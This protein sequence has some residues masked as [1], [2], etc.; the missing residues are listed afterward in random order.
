MQRG[1]INLD[2]RT[3]IRDSHLRNRIH[4][5]LFFDTSA[6]AWNYYYYFI[7]SPATDLQPRHKSFYLFANELIPW[8]ITLKTVS[9]IINLHSSWE[10]KTETQFLSVSD[11][12]S[13]FS[14]LFDESKGKKQY[15]DD[16]NLKN[17]VI[18]FLMLQTLVCLLNL[19]TR[20]FAKS[21]CSSYT[22]NAGK[23]KHAKLSQP[24]SRRSNKHSN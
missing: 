16:F 11:W 17:F 12:S 3:D 8:K 2:A 14:L 15:L 1:V 18:F 23:S 20:L 24:N 10:F 21:C 19:V 6:S 4:H 5:R 13:T 22:S 9:I 7:R